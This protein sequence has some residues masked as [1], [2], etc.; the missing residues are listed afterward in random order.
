MNIR[1]I[2]LLPMILLAMTAMS[3]CGLNELSYQSGYDDGYNAG[4]QSGVKL[5]DASSIPVRVSGSFTVTV[6]EL[7][8]DYVADSI[9]PRAAV[10]T[11]FQDGPFVLKLDEAVCQELTAGEA[12]TFLVE[13]QEVALP[14]NELLDGG[15]VSQN[16][17]LLRHISVTGVRAATEEELGLDGWRV[18]YAT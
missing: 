18:S 2:R 4:Y 17:L 7:I 13:E 6:R 10:V 16:A 15:V 14:E 1:Q 12:Y 9:T 8:P 3:G 5:L 11:F